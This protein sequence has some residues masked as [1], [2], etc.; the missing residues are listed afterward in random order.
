MKATASHNSLASG[1]TLLSSVN[2]SQ[3][4]HLD[5]EGFSDRIISGEQCIIAD[6]PFIVLQRFSLKALVAK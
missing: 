6:N 5:L 3:Y 2:L 4:S 1:S